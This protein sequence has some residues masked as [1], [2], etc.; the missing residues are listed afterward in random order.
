MIV[1]TFDL[2]INALFFFS[3]FT[4]GIIVMCLNKFDKK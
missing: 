3:G 2:M 4:L 1:T